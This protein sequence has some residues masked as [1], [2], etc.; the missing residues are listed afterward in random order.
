MI[1]NCVTDKVLPSASVS[2][3]K[4]FPVAGV[5]SF[6]VFVLSVAT[7]ASFTAV[8]VIANVPVSELVPSVIVYV[9]TGTVPL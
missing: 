6:T 2:F 3:V 8:T 9:I 1:S 7:G 5:S 4:T